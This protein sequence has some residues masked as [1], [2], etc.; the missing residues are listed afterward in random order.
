MGTGKT[1]L[2]GNRFDKIKDSER[3]DLSWISEVNSKC[4]LASPE[5]KAETHED[6]EK[7]RHDAGTEME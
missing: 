7:R 6:K 3:G 1:T 2:N 5:E 4:N